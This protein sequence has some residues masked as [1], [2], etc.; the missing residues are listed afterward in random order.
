MD[1]D[2]DDADGIDEARKEDGGNE[3]NKNDDYGINNKI[4]QFL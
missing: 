3:D 2:E 1:E 4:D